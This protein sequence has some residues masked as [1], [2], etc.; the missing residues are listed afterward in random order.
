[1]E[2]GLFVH[3]HACMHVRT[4]CS[5]WCHMV[6]LVFC[7]RSQ[8]EMT[9]LIQELKDMI[10]NKQK[11]KTSA[12]KGTTGVCGHWCTPATLPLNYDIMRPQKYSPVYFPRLSRVCQ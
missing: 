9:K 6:S 12:A 7:C 11:P 3:E 8:G 4:Y 1:M 5:G 10:D 2:M